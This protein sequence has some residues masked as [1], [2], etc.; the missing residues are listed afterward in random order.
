MTENSLFSKITHQPW[1]ECFLIL[2]SFP[3]LALHMACIGQ[4]ADAARTLLQLG[5][6][7]SEDA[8]G[9]TAQQHAKKPE[10]VKV[11][12]PDNQDASV[13]W[14][15]LYLNMFDSSKTQVTSGNM[16]HVGAWSILC[17][18]QWRSPGSHTKIFTE[19]L[20]LDKIVVEIPVKLHFSS[21]SWIKV[22]CSKE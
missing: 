12:K 20:I 2:T 15:V 14:E 22:I 5:L 3:P 7:D 1:F 4:H 21:V 10:I 16:V 9:A 18:L 8:L 17:S 13:H 11:F 6:E 19:K